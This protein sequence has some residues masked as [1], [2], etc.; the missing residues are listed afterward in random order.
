MAGRFQCHGTAIM[1][2]SVGL[3]FLW[4]G[5]LKLFPATSPAEGV[6]VRAAMK[7]TFGLMQPDTVLMSLALCELAIGI[8]LTTGFLLR[9]ALAAFFAHMTGVFSALFVLP[10]EMWQSDS[11]VPTME[12]QYIIKNVVLVAACLTVAADELNRPRTKRG[13]AFGKSRPL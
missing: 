6:A 10:G 2:V 1:R 13:F 5:A 11:V 4:F 8:G 12:G 9:P 7:L 3:V